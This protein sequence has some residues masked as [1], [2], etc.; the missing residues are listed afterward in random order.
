MDDEITINFIDY[1]KKADENG[2][3][4]DKNI[5]AVGDSRIIYKLGLLTES[6]LNGDEKSFTTYETLYNLLSPEAKYEMEEVYEALKVEIEN[7]KK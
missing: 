3:Y 5:P 6:V 7:N 2:F 4:P 1:T